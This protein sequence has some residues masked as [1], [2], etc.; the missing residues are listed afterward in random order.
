M[1]RTILKIHP[2]DNVAVALRGLRAGE[3]VDGLTI[4]SEIPAGHK[5]ALT[6]I[7]AGAKVIKYGYSIGT[8]REAIAAGS[9]VHTQNLASEL[10]HDLIAEAR[11]ARPAPVRKDQPRVF[12]GYRRSDGRVATRNEVWIIPTVGCVNQAALKIAERANARFP[13]TEHFDGIYAYP[14]PFGCSQLGGDLDNTRRVLAGLLRH[15]NAAAVLVIGLGCE[16]NQMKALLAE[17]GSGGHGDRIRYFNAQDVDD[18]IAAGV[19]AVE[20]LAA[21][22]QQARREPIPARELILGMKCGGSDGFSGVTANP[23]VGRVADRLTAQ[24]G[25]TLLSEVPEMF[26]AEQMLLDR[27]ASQGVASDIVSLVNEFRAY[28]RRYNQ[29]IDENPSPG[30]KAGGL[31]SNADKS[32]GCLQK[33]GDAPIQRVLEYGEPIEVGGLSGVALVNAPGNDG[34]SATAMTVAGAHL[35]LFTTGRGTP[36]GFPV[37]TVKIASN[38]NL[39]ARKPSWIDFDAGRLLADDADADRMADELFN[40]V[41]DIASGRRQTRNEI[42][43]NREIAIWKDGVTL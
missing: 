11:A 17:A 24:G 15:P 2:N 10:Q 30:N 4:D 32:L 7:P 42:N 41:L 43:D 16:N 9:H 35:I 38:S 39:A 33:A 18:E 3:V 20:Q 12:C 21:L 8:A 36:M 13:Q 37:P 31:S 14:H 6:A 23:L 1:M 19:A 29:P 34:V 28:F 40:V 27:A 5:I 25:T 22:A 26:G